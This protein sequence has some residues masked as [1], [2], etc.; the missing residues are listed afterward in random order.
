MA[1]SFAPYLSFTLASVCPTRA[2][3]GGF[4]ACK[5]VKPRLREQREERKP[6]CR[7]TLPALGFALGKHR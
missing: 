3:L 7:F 1:V 5:L 4:K 2:M 6:E